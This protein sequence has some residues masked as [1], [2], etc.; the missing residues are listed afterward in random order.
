MNTATDTL[1]VSRE[2]TPATPAKAWRAYQGV[3][4][5]AV[6]EKDLIE[7]Y[8]PLVRNV[9][10]RIKLN[11]PAHVDADDL[12]SVG[13]TGLIAAVRKFDPQQGCTFASYAAMRIRGSILDELRRMDWCPRRARARSRKLKETIVEVE[14]KLGRAATDLEVCTALGL[15]QKDYLK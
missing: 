6:D 14:Q 8:L 3:S 4:P 2:A 12:Y 1:P 7:R 10:D 5:A 15:S 13:I 11:V 9:V